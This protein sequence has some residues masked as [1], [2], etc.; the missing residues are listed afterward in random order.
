MTRTTGHR[1][2]DP[3]R[4]DRVVVVRRSS[5]I[6]RQRSAPDVGVA[7]VLSAGGPLADRLEATH[8]EHVRTCDAVEAALLAAGCRVRVV[9]G[10]RRRDV[11]GADLIITIGGD[12]TFLRAS[13]CVET[14]ADGGSV[15]MLGINSAPR[16]SVGFFCAATADDFPAALATLAAFEQ[17]GRT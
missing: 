16:S 13:H 5:A 2:G 17:A 14:A 4:V 6:E 7:R 3:V 9:H 12:G 1:V 8:L 10:L 11:V 15:P